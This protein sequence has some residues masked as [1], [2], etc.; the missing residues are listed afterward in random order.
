MSRCRSTE[1]AAGWGE[2]GCRADA[3]CQ[4]RR[5]SQFE[6]YTLMETETEVRVILATPASRRNHK[7]GVRRR[8]L[9][10][11]IITKDFLTIKR[12]IILL[13][14]CQ[15]FFS[16][17]LKMSSEA[18]VAVGHFEGQ[19]HDV[20]GRNNREG[21][22]H[23]LTQ[24]VARRHSGFMYTCTVRFWDL[25]HGAEAQTHLCRMRPLM[26]SRASYTIRASSTQSL[27]SMRK[28]L[29]VRR[30]KD[31]GTEVSLTWQITLPQDEKTFKGTFAPRRLAYNLST[32]CEPGRRIKDTKKHCGT[33]SFTLIRWLLYIPAVFDV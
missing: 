4:A 12:R 1:G 10:G 33:F 30:M 29:T 26:G 11:N 20:G 24:P 8:R 21:A 7:S 6:T 9:Y 17:G 19:Q 32:H 23:W 18:F 31:P 14:M 15:T 2:R 16:Y 28:E 5:E 25:R 22:G 27:G 3:W 13:N